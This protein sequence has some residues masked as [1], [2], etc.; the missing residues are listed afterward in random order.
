MKKAI[1]QII[2]LAFLV[3]TIPVIEVSAE[4]TDCYWMTCV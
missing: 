2:S 3:S 1:L 4:N